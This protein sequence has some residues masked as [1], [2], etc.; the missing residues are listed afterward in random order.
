MKNRKVIVLIILAVI[1]IFS[2]YYG[3]TSTP[4]GRG[5]GLLREGSIYNGKGMGIGDIVIPQK[6]RA[7]RTNFISWGKNPFSPESVS[8]AASGLSGILWDKENPKAIINELIV[9]IGDE[10]G[11]SIVKDIKEDKVILND[12]AHDFELRL[13][14]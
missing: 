6:R 4:E 7:K 1:A 5:R 9:G 14:Q 10:V 3:V 11:G 8:M 13:D 12:G 2:L